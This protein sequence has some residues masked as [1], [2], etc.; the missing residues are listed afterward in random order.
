[1]LDGMAKKKDGTKPAKE[2]GEDEKEDMTESKE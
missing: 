2:N 1:M